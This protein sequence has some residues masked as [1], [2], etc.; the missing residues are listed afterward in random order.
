MSSTGYLEV[1][2]TLVFDENRVV[3]F[4]F[5]SRRLGVDVNLA[6][7]ILFE[8]T[9]AKSFPGQS[10]HSIFCICGISQDDQKLVTLVPQEELEAF[11]STFKVLTSVH[12]YSVQPCR[13]KDSSVFVAP[14]REKPEVVKELPICGI[15]RN[16]TI[17]LKEK[18]LP[19]QDTPQDFQTAA[20]AEIK[21]SQPL[22]MSKS[23]AEAPKK[24]ELSKPSY[25]LQS[26]TQTSRESNLPAKKKSS[27]EAQKKNLQSH[28]N[29]I[30]KANEKHEN[31]FF[32]KVADNKKKSKQIK[33][34]SQ[35]KSNKPDIKISGK[36]PRK[37]VII[38]A[39]E[40]DDDDDEEQ[41]FKLAATND[42]IMEEQVSVLG[43]VQTNN[44]KMEEAL[45]HFEDSVD[46]MDIDDDENFKN[47]KETR[48]NS[49]TP[50]SPQEAL[51][52][53][54]G[55]RK[56]AKQKIT[57]NVKGYRVVEDV[58]EWESYSEDEAPQP[59]FKIEH[60]KVERPTKQKA[61]VGDAPK[62]SGKKKNLPTAQ[63]DLLA[64]FGKK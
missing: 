51:K 31:S 35:K 22:D 53:R 63:S 6:K 21:N 47:P 56:V 33:E 43:D 10:I 15:I 40:E 9:N 2:N 17:T 13:P 41:D 62:R 39:S 38:D 50:Q 1:L 57:K 3:T 55:K 54:R 37:R 14:N 5:L 23:K 48:I 29:S 26:S 25:K 46:N 27:V 45:P 32:G 12:V 59:T 34:I 18:F 16:K 30:K 8:F 19:H 60:K 49:L 24:S 36:P 64:F 11:K 61:E 4:K 52:G 7:Q 58:Y 28:K 44:F 42:P 20:N